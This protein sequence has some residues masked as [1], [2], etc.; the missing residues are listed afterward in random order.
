MKESEIE[1][2][3]VAL[4]N[5]TD[6]SPWN[7]PGQNTRVVS[8]SLLQGIFPTQGLNWGLPHCRQILYQLSQQGSPRMLES[9]AYPFSSGS[10]QP[11]DRTRVSCTAGRF[12]TLN[13]RGSPLPPGPSPNSSLSRYLAG[14]WDTFLVLA[15]IQKRIWERGR[16]HCPKHQASLRGDICLSLLWGHHPHSITKRTYRW[17]RQ[18]FK[19]IFHCSQIHAMNK[20]RDVVLSRMHSFLNLI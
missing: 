20:L 3:S 16:D 10:S 5:P 12:F 11:R 6:Y 1:S 4:C 7:S 8:L 2:H 9:V 13:Y 18:P 19:T 17:C 15:T 14:C